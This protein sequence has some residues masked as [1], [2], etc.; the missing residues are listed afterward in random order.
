MEM[1]L[2]ARGRADAPRAVF[3]TLSAL[4]LLATSAI[5]RGQDLDIP[6]LA[7][8][9]ELGDFTSMNP[10]D[11]V[12]ARYAVVSGFLQRSPQDGA[13]SLQRTDVYLGYDKSNLYAVFVAFDTEPG[14]VRANLAPR[15]NIDY[16]DRVGLLLDTFNDQRT[17][18]AFRSS[19]VGVQW[20]ARWSEVSRGSTFD[21][22]YEAVWYTDAQTTSGGYVVKMT[23]PF[24]A[25]RFPETGEQLWRIQFERWIPRFS[26]ASFWPAYSQSV[27]GRL[28]QAATLAGVRDVS[29]GRNMQLIPFAFV[30]SF[31]VL[32][33]DPAAPQFDDDT[34]DDVG[35]D[36]KFV[37]RDSFVLDLT[38]NPD[39]SQVESDQPQVTVNERF[40]V[41]FPERRPFFLEN[42]DYFTTETPLVFTRRIVDPEAGL[43]FTGRLGP[44]GV[45]TMLIDDEAP[46]TLVA[47]TSPLRGDAANIGVLRAFRDL[48]DQSRAGVLYTEREFGDAYNRVGAVDTHVKLSDNWSTELLMVNTDTRP[49]SG[50]AFSG[51]Q[52]NWRFD[53]N[54]RHA[55]VHA[56]WTQQSDGFA[57]QLG[58]LGRNYQPD[59]K[60]LHGNLEYRFWR[61]EGSWLDRI[62]PRLFHAHQEDQSGQRIYAE[63][64][65]A[66]L[67]AWSGDSNLS[68]GTNSIRERLRERDFP[69]LL[70]ARD[71]KQDRWYGEFWTEMFA[72][73]GFYV[74]YD[75]GTVINLV[76]RLG[77]QPELADRRYWQTEVR[78]RPSQRLRIDTNY[79][80]TR[81][82]DRFGGG[83]IFENRIL[84]N[85]WNYQ[86]TKEMSVRF[87]AQ[88]EETDPTASLTR[89]ERDR[90][91]N[92]DVLF[93]YV[94]NPWSALYVGYN[95]NRSNFQLV[96]LDEPNSSG[97]MRELVPTDDLARDGSQLFVKFSYLLQR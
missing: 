46:G 96:E 12:R 24:R 80:F 42:A 34:E 18:Y 50:P 37:L 31:D 90:N 10:S 83:Q 87:I 1:V 91:L 51:R 55:L 6:V 66:L 61:P 3:R 77:S 82:D 89:L 64:S 60:G 47:P 76:P 78:L 84:R 11:A 25:M 35:L 81:L 16:D 17:A 40:E 85:R 65:P 32:N 88:L 74:F 5:A 30:R 93:R 59:S 15:E 69:G 29:P 92:F 95:Q 26:E 54:G 43:K 48:G 33:R 13:P 67:M 68:F 38:Y 73:A 20:D 39:F 44:W 72:K 62:G 23:I 41:Q 70:A 97:A 63:L 9:P 21:T 7:A 58:I 57:P 8:P 53:R 22:S 79:L 14:N 52:T 75:E 71:Y 19:P 4:L 49:A 28:N 27:D 45:G 94:L 86:F 2:A 56:H 36:A